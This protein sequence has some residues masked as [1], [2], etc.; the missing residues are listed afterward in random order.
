VKALQ[1]SLGIAMRDFVEL[2]L[3]FAFAVVVPPLLEAALT[4]RGVEIAGTNR[5]LLIVTLQVAWALFAFLLMALK[6][7]PL[8][9]VGLARPAS[10]GRTVALGLILAAF[11]FATVAT[12]EHLG[13]G[14]ERL[15]DIGQELKGNVGLVIQRVVVSLLVVG[16]V[17]EFIFRGFV[18]SRIAGIF[19]GG[20]WAWGLMPRTSP[21]FL[22]KAARRS[23][24]GSLARPGV[25]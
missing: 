16:F 19:G 24:R 14:R 1:W 11:I 13:Y 17:E 9:T 22:G 20:N 12:L 3:V 4:Q 21:G 18:M 23:E 10:L 6:R 5:I 7:E 8:S 25:G 15:G 2:L